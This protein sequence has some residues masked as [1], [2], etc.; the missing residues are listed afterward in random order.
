MSHST[1][2]PLSDSKDVHRR[3]AVKLAMHADPRYTKPWQIHAYTRRHLPEHVA[4][5]E[6]GMNENIISSSILPYLDVTTL[7]ETS[8]SVELPL[9]LLVSK[10]AHAWTWEHPERNAAALRFI[11]AAERYSAGNL[12]LPTPWGVTWAK[13]PGPSEILARIDSFVSLGAAPLGG[14]IAVATAARRDRVELWDLAS[15]LPTPLRFQSDNVSAVAIGPAPHG[16]AIVAVGTEDGLVRCWLVPGIGPGRAA[17]P[18][19]QDLGYF[20]VGD[21]VTA[22][23]VTTILHRPHIL[24][25]QANGRVT[26][27]D[28][29]EE[30]QMPPR[31]IH[32]GQVT[33]ITS[34]QLG[35]G[36]PAAVSVGV[37]GTVRLSHLGLWPTPIG[38]VLHSEEAIKAVAVLRLAGG[39]AVAVTG[40]DKGSVRVWD[41]PPEAPGCRRVPGHD[42]DVTAVA[43]LTGPPGEPLVVTG[44]AHGRLRIVD[45]DEAEVI[46]GPIE[47]HG[48][49]VTGLALE[50][51]IDGR[52]IAVSGGGDGIVRSWDLSGLRRDAAQGVAA[53]GAPHPREPFIRLWQLD[54]GSE[55]G[56]E[57]GAHSHWMTA[58]AVGQLGDGTP[59]AVTDAGSARQA[60]V[61]RGTTIGIATAA[62]P[63]GGTAAVSVS[64]DGQLRFCDLTPCPGLPPRVIY[65]ASHLGARAVITATRADGR[66]VAVTAGRDCALKI[67][68]MQNAQRPGGD[69]TGHERPVTALAVAAAPG[70]RTVVVSGSE[71]ASLRV[72]DL[73]AGRQVGATFRGYERRITSLAATWVGDRLIAVT[74]GRGDPVVRWCDLLAVGPGHGELIGHDGP[75]TAIAVLAARERPLVVTASEDHTIRVWDLMK[76]APLQV[77]GQEL[78]PMPVPG[79]VRAIACFDA[80]GPSAL[81]AGDD[82]LAAVRWAPL[83]LAPFR[84][85]SLRFPR[86]RL[87]K[88]KRE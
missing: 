15:G 44:D 2:G 27:V 20:D 45:P 62:L 17:W 18:G 74:V 49:R 64:G 75:V 16:G 69:L 43:A 40:G 26:L 78:S 3:I 85:N 33:G 28:C 86:Y 67:W 71:D 72:W 42:H 41:L 47:G 32:Q 13:S 79:A 53:P 34:I 76:S 60:V 66:P 8:S 36:A 14:R 50:R 39:K 7:K 63:G 9:M 12:D 38:T 10:V 37:D 87:G 5:A 81:I 46:A 30:G 21:A 56:G 31:L 11:V 73:D 23:S 1:S 35:N 70:P 19:D 84:F 61:G 22:L 29:G 68:D 24:A 4:A 80:S 65:T 77:R 58:V 6:E 88:R 57:A 55:L 52:A 51:S 83:G 48:N 54:D 59:V 25:G 82:V